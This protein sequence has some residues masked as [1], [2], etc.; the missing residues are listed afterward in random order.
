MAAIRCMSLRSLAPVGVLL[1]FVS[2]ISIKSDPKL[3]IFSDP[4]GATILVDGVD[5]GFTT[6]A[7][8]EPG[9][10]SVTIIKDGYLPVTRAV[11]RTTNFRYPRWNDGGTSDFSLAVSITRTTDDFFFPLQWDTRSSPRRVFVRLEPAPKDGAAPSQPP[12]K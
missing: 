2:C 4:E 9:V 11:R 8:L 1:F 3:F 6:P 7:V 10:A 5:C 12:V